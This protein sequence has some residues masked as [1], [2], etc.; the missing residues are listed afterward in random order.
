MI[1]LKIEG[2]LGGGVGVREFSTTTERAGAQPKS[3]VKSP[4]P[5]S[6]ARIVRR[7]PIITRMTFPPALRI[8]C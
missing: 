4:I 8:F 5:S 1:T 2:L 3:P 6:V 7:N